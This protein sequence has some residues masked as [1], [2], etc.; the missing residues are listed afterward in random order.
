MLAAASIL[1]HAE[2]MLLCGRALRSAIPFRVSKDALAAPCYWHAGLAWWK[3]GKLI[4]FRNHSSLDV[5]IFRAVALSN[6]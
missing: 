3:E 2:A 4:A 5:L 6:I 1:A